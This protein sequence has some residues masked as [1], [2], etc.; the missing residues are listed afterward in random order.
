MWPSH[1]FTILGA[2]FKM[3]FVNLRSEGTPAVSS[4]ASTRTQTQTSLGSGAVQYYEM[5]SYKKQYC[6]APF[7]GK[8]F[9]SRLILRELLVV[10]VMI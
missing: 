9:V 8:T 5:E 1:P 4:V 2:F 3:G 7:S 10:V 6:M